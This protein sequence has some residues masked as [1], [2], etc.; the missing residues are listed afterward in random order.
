MIP[1]CLVTGF[2]GSGKSTL[3][4]HIIERHPGERIVY[5]VNEFSPLDLDGAL[6]EREDEDVVAI[7]GG[8]IFCQCLVTQFVGHL[9][10]IPER[11]HSPEEPVRGVVVEASGIANPMV[12]EQMLA[13]TGLDEV[14]DLASVVSIVDPGSLP[15][16]VHTLPNIRA[17][18]EAADIVLVNKTDLFEPEEVDA[19]EGIVR[20]ISAQARV[21]RTVR[22]RVDLDIFASAHVRTLSGE[23]ASGPDPNFARFS[24]AF[25]EPVDI[26][27]LRQE[28]EGL[29]RE[30]YRAKGFV[31][32]G[33]EVLYVD[34]S[35]AELTVESA[36]GDEPWQGLVVVARGDDHAGTEQLVR[37]IESGDLSAG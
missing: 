33:D 35:P 10:S 15:K 36:D 30:I 20:E 8:S 6:L 22:C 18:V 29:E 3:L 13:E 21:I 27:R 12:V 11:F 23:Y 19:A 28:L 9:K 17:Q 16:L 1:I 32:T 14:Y 37:R 7:P 34:M 2:L 31:P 4:R 5:L 25:E 24:V 26:E